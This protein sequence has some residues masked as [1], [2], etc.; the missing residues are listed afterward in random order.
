VTPSDLLVDLS[1]CVEV[2]LAEEQRPPLCFNGPIPGD[3]VTAAWIGE[4]AEGGPCG[5]A[6]VRVI[7]AYPATGVGIVDQTA[8]NCG[9]NIGLDI[10]VGILRCTPVGAEDAEQEEVDALASSREQMAD[11]LTLRKAISCC[12]SL[13]KSD[14]VLGTWTPMGPLGGVVG[15]AWTVHA[16]V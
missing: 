12:P 6:W 11:L 4:C 13:A 1:A 14:Y 10:E 9:K 8:N 7:L 15:G 2:T 3:G 5:M 16:V